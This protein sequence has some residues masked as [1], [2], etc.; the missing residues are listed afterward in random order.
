MHQLPAAVL[1][2]MDGTLV[3]SEEYWIEVE[4]QLARADG[5]HW[6]KADGVSL[7]GSAIP[8][9]ARELRT[10]GGV[11]GTD[12][13]I[14]DRLISGVARLMRERGIIWRPGAREFLDSMRAAAIPM[15]LVTMSYR[16]LADTVAASLPTGTFQAI[17][18]GDAVTHGKPHP[19]PYLT[20]AARIGVDAERCIGIEDSPTGLASVEAA[21]A[22]SIGIPCLVEI[23]PAQGRSRVSSLNELGL[24][25]LSL[26]ASGQ[27]IDRLR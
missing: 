23:P 12:E 6:T 27:V 20:A 2:D 4:M 21:G 16:E 11:Q 9:S 3:E 1:C 17:V 8:Y 22:R 10:R 7:I 24:H 13:Q 15:A 18:A 14:V 5:G 25:E 19:E 26:I